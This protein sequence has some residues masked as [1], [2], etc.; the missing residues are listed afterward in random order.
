MSKDRE[1]LSQLDEATK[2]LEESE[3]NLLRAV[4]LI[5]SSLA[6]AAHQNFSQSQRTGWKG[7]AVIKAAE[8]LAERAAAKAKLIK[9][10]I[11]QFTM[12]RYFRDL[13]AAKEDY[14]DYKSK[15]AAVREIND[16]L[17][18]CDGAIR[19]PDTGKPCII[20]AVASRD[21][22]GRYVFEERETKTRSNASKALKELLPFTLM[23]D[24][25]RKEAIVERRKKQAQAK[26]AKNPKKD[27]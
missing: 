10:V 19:H 26:P 23:P 24:V 11:N 15:L 21:G 8:E 14:K 25:P 1:S 7:Y 12:N 20:L 27:G 13:V 4:D 16:I 17:R 9:I 3:A 18:S 22:F 5:D 6:L 2:L